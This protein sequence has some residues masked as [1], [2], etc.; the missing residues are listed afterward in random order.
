MNDNS[1]RD[2]QVFR[3]LKLEAVTNYL[4]AIGWSC[5]QT[6]EGKFSVWNLD[7]NSRELMVPEK[8]SFADYPIRIAEVVAELANIQERSPQAVITDI[9]ACSSDIDLKGW[10]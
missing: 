1:I 6:V 10:K 4:H 7:D 3:S 9:K 2:P 8:Q 5:V